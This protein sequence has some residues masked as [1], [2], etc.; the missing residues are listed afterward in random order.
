MEIGCGRV[1]IFPSKG[2]L[3]PSQ[4]MNFIIRLQNGV[5]P[6]AADRAAVF[7]MV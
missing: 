7:L 5:H 6:R 3:I 1:I 4:G 2:G